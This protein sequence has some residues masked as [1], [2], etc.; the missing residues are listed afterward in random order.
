MTLQVGTPVVKSLRVPGG[1]KRTLCSLCPDVL[2][3]EKPRFLWPW[4]VEMQKRLV[5]IPEREAEKDPKDF[6]GQ[7]C[8]ETGGNSV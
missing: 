3:E 2:T 5:V 1:A 7:R 4:V 6:P 8:L